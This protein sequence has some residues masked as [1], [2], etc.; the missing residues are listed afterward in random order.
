MRKKPISKRSSAKAEEA[1]RTSLE[2]EIPLLG[3][4]FF[5]RARIRVGER[6]VREAN[7]T[8]SRRGR[9][10]LGDRAKVQ[11]SLR[12]SPEVIE[13]FRSGG[14]GWQARIDEVLR[15]HVE[16]AQTRSA[17]NEERE[18]YCADPAAASG[19]TWKRPR[20]RRLRAGEAELRWGEPG[21]LAS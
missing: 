15:H 1:S 6:V 8:L 19:R 10:P 13:H 7:G 3:S 12:L 4:D 18:A 5:E 2:G 20:I 16:I 21:L 14:G 9:P 11:Q 17:V